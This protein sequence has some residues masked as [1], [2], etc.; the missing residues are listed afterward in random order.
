MHSLEQIKHM[1]T[2]A[3]VAK[4]QA[5]ARAMNRRNKHASKKEKS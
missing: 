5:L 2:P 4:R 1:N 3:E